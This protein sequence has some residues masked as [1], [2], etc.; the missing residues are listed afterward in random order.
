MVVDQPPPEPPVPGEPP[1]I[2]V[3]RLWVSLL[4]PPV[5]V[6]VAYL[7]ILEYFPTGDG[8]LMAIALLTLGLFTAW[9]VMVCRVKFRGRS[10]VLMAI[11]Y[12]ILQLILFTTCLIGACFLAFSQAH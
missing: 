2:A 12:V 11:G 5:L 3:G 9:F 1:K 8:L 10:L 6:C 7:I 4:L